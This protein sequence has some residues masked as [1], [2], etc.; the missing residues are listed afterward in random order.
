MDF[1]GI[2]SWSETNRWH[3][4]P[5]TGLFGVRLC[6][7][8]H[9]CTIFF[10]FGVHHLDL[11]RCRPVTSFF[12]SC[13]TK[14]GSESDVSSFQTLAALSEGRLGTF[15]SKK[16]LV[17]MRWSAN[18]FSGHVLVRVLF[19][20]PPSHRVLPGDRV[21]HNGQPHVVHARRGRFRRT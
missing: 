18:E 4:S 21:V 9:D 6:S 3:S 14:S 13:R 19:E 11:Q 17:P 7:I 16:R 2:S 10:R 1:L 15:G 20:C 5:K 12:V 8:L